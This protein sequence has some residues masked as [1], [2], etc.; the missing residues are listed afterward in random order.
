[1]KDKDERSPASGPVRQTAPRLGNHS[2]PP[3][4][5]RPNRTSAA[6][7]L[8]EQPNSDVASVLGSEGCRRILRLLL[9]DPELNLDSTSLSRLLG[10][11]QTQISLHLNDLARIGLL[12]KQRRGLFMVYRASP[13]FRARLE[14]NIKV[15]ASTDQ[16]PVELILL[17]HGNHP[18]R[19][20]GARTEQQGK[21]PAIGRSRVIGST[22]GD[23]HPTVQEGGDVDNDQTDHDEGEPSHPLAI[24]GEPERVSPRPR[25]DQG[26]RLGRARRTPAVVERSAKTAET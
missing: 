10:W 4:V 9:V 3:Y 18:N 26:D 14:A 24:A 12:A 17:L 22:A 11:H 25:P 1:M 23:K 8:G 20:A 19:G 13:H 7:T 21:A 15:P 5:A 6:S 2:D 16:L